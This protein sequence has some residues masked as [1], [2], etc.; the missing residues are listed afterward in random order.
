VLD[1][2]HVVRLGFAAVDDVRRRVQQD[3][4]GHRSRRG[5][6]LYGIRRVLH[7]DA[8]NLY[9]ATYHAWLRRAR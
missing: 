7:R 9:E 4:Y 1:P 3:T 8:D 6:P 5:D 2:F